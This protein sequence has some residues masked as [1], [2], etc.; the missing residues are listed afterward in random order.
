MNSSPLAIV[1]AA[2]KGSRMKSD[3]PKVLFPVCGRP[4]IH[5]V[6]DALDKAGFKNQVAVVGHRAEDVKAELETR[7]TPPKFALQREQLGTGHAV[8]QCCEFL[9][10]HKGPVLVV[11]GDSPLIQPSSLEKLLTYFE[12]HRPSLLLGTLI[13]ADPKGLGRI[14]RNP[15][16]EFIGSWSIAMQPK[17]NCSYAK[18]T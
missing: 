11:A 3:L 17:N 1:L 7:P 13:K 18:S 5:F 12:S 15:D 9:D 8:M 14:V 16:G 6:L 2:G 10:G 4:M